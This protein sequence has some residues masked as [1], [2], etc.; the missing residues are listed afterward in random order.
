MIIQRIEEKRSTPLS[1]LQT[2]PLSLSLSLSPQR[3]FPLWIGGRLIPSG[4]QISADSS[5]SCEGKEEIRARKKESDFADQMVR[6]LVLLVTK[7]VC[8]YL[9]AIICYK[10][11]ENCLFGNRTT[12]LDGI[13]EFRFHRWTKTSRNRFQEVEHISSTGNCGSFVFPQ[14][15]ECFHV[16]ETGLFRWQFIRIW[17]GSRKNSHTLHP[18]IPRFFSV[19]GNSYSPLNSVTK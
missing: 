5:E 1:L 16:C 10:K 13:I 4:L 18:L 14:V 19:S 12:L 17:V 8:E 15:N 11:D 6:W 9:T 3:L 7:A 2:L